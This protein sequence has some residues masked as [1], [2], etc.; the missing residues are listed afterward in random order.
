MKTTTSN[1]RLYFSA[2]VLIIIS[3][4]AY[5]ETVNTGNTT[6]SNLNA[7]VQNNN[8]VINWMIA[9]TT[10]ANTNFCEVQASND[11]INFSSIGMVLGADPKAPGS[12]SFKQNLA[13]IKSGKLF[14]RI[15]TVESG[16][17][18]YTSNIIQADK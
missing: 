3:T 15:L 12:F 1:L 7:A 8:L 16:G 9:E 17:R 18:T 5:S 10:S 2:L 11:G 14:Y 13:K 4:N 6:I